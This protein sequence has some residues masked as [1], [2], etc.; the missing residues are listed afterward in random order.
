MGYTTYGPDYHQTFVKMAI[1]L[2]TISATKHNAR[3]FFVNRTMIGN[4]MEETLR[5]HFK[6]RAMVEVPLFQFQA[7]KL[8]ENFEAAIKATQVAEQKIKRVQAEQSMRLVEYQTNVIQAQRYVQVR[9]QQANGVAQSIHL[10]NVADIASFNAS[11]MKTLNA[12]K[13]VLRMFDG[14]AD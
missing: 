2:L 11:Q 12:F 9:T 3:D 1:D 10:Q 4:M 6:T 13:Q 7:V 8:P 5:Q 14:D